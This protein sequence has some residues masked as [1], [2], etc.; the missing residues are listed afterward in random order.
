MF[1]DGFKPNGDLLYF[2]SSINLE[3]LV[4]HNAD[5]G[6]DALQNA[7]DAG[8][9]ADPRVLDIL[10]QVGFKVDAPRHSVAN[11]LIGPITTPLVMACER[12]QPSNVKNLL[13]A[14]A[15]PNGISDSYEI[16]KVPMFGMFRYESP[17]PILVILLS[18]RWFSLPTFPPIDPWEIGE[19]FIL[20]FQSLNRH[21]ALI[22]PHFLEIL[23]FKIWLLICRR[24]ITKDGFVLP[25]C[26]NHPKHQNLGV[27][28]LLKALEGA[29]ITPFDRVC[30]VVSDSNPAS[31]QM[32]LSG[33]V[34]DWKEKAQQINGK[35][36]LLKFL[37]EYQDHYN[38]LPGPAQVQRQ[39]TWVIPDRYSAQ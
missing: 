31:F 20:C 24:M 7:I 35:A 37:C 21:G 13:R 1:P 22:P 25:N 27:R 4:S 12:L 23:L 2:S 39:S 9:H 36:R 15:K 8:D 38:D 5:L 11:Y 32:D 3:F 17:N 6:V 26:D 33:T 10:L 18:E 34:I 14:G 28:S 19:R 16:T 30:Q 29:D